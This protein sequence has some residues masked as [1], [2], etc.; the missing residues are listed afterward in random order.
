[1]KDSD[2]FC[3]GPDLGCGIDTAGRVAIS[4]CVFWF[5]SALMTCA[6]GKERMDADSDRDA[7]AAPEPEDPND[8]ERMDANSDRDADAAPEPEV[9]AEVSVEDKGDVEVDAA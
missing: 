6:H 7:D 1:M 8:K 2:I 5:V 9:Q 3:D 4:A